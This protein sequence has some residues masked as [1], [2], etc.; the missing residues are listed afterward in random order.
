[1]ITKGADANQV[2]LDLGLFTL[3]GEKQ[4]F[5]TDKY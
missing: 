3:Q 2:V 5:L 4:D 1:M